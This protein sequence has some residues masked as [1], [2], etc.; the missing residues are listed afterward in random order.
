MWE[1]IKKELKLKIPNGEYDLWIN[2][3]KQGNFQNNILY[4]TVPNNIYIQQIESHYLSIMKTVV[5]LINNTDLQINY[6]INDETN[7]PIP[8]LPIT[9]S[10]KLDS[11]KIT[12]Q[13]LDPNLKNHLE[14]EKYLK[15]SE[16]TNRESLEY[17]NVVEMTPKF[18]SKSVVSIT[19]MDS[20]YFTYSTDRRKSA[21]VDVKYNFTNEES[22]V[23]KLY[24]GI[25]AFGISAVGQLTTNHA[26]ILFAI[27]HT[28]Q[29]NGCKFNGS[30]DQAVVDLSLRQLITDLGYTSISGTIF[31]LIYSRIKD[32]IHYPYVLSLDGIQGLGF[33][34]LS[35]MNTL[36]DKN[37]YNKLIIRLIFNPFISRQL[38][39]RKAFY[40]NPQCYLLRNAIALKFLLTYDKTIFMGNSIKVT[41]Q[42]LANNLEIVYKRQDVLIKA[43]NRALNILNGYELS[44]HYNLKIELIKENNKHYVIAGR[45]SKNKQITAA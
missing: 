27:I 40:R 17:K 12:Q 39:D 32:L 9:S 8:V 20:K 18:S 44:E 7:T 1:T 33:T 6:N 4:L 21:I 35:S 34:F 25:E 36:S 31:K 30:K 5:K 26:R 10:P 24:R 14:L 43:L 3:I 13:H 23:Y 42:D 37:N 29:K 38:Y 45:Y 41:I 16:D 19:S 11:N 15:K 28:W 22:K 2:T